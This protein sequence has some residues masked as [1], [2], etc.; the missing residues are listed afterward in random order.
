MKSKCDIC[1]KWVALK[2][3][4]QFRAH[5]YRRSGYDTYGYCDGKPWH[6]LVFR[7]PP[8]A[9]DVWEIG[10]RVFGSLERENEGPK[11]MREYIVVNRGDRTRRLI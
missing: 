5:G 6:T 3:N 7:S 9:P 10:W 4:G 11:W 2:K 8:R 1:G